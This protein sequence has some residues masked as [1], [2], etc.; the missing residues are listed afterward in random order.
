MSH[1]EIISS[2]DIKPSKYR[3]WHIEKDFQSDIFSALRKK[4]WIC[5]KI[6]DIG[7]GTKFLDGICISPEWH[8]V[9]LEFKKIELYTFNLSQFEPSQVALLTKLWTR[10]NVEVYVPIFSKGKWEYKVFTFAEL[11]ELAND[12]WGCKIF[13][14]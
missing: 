12:K 9:F 11:K 10:P 7:L 5:Y 8:T 13:N 4:N 3:K 1:R 6:A 2:V 14:K